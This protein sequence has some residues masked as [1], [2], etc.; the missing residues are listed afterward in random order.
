MIG[1]V[2]LVILAGGEGRRIGGAK[3]QRRLAGERLIDRAVLQARQW[4][5]LV[6]IAVRDPCQVQP[7]EVELLADD[8]LIEGPLSGLVSA[9]RFATMKGRALLLAIP[10]D[11]P[12][13]PTDLLERLSAGIGSAKC[14]LASSGGHLHPVCS[15]WR[16]SALSD[17]ESYLETGRRSLRGFASFVGVKIVEWPSK[18]PDP[19]FNVNTRDDLSRAERLV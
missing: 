8:P 2:A 13:L 1:N 3:P 11:M 17:V 10:S 14:A 5:D 16:T 12:I 7:V 9:L 19:F 4:S 6:A 18:S 15:L